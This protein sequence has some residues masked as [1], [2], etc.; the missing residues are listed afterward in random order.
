MD[1]QQASSSG[2]V[3]AEAR[4]GGAARWPASALTPPGVGEDEV[5]ARVLLG[6]AL[7]GERVSG[8]SQEPVGD[9]PQPGPRRPAHRTGPVDGPHL[10]KERAAGD[11]GEHT[12]APDEGE[13]ADGA[14]PA[15]DHDDARVPLWRRAVGPRAA[16]DFEAVFERLNP[17]FVPSD[18]AVVH[19]RRL[20]WLRARRY[21]VPITIAVAPIPPFLPFIGP[22]FQ[23]FSLA[24]TYALVPRSLQLQ[25]GLGPGTAAVVALIPGVVFGWWCVRCFKARRKPGFTLRL[26][27]FTLLI[28]WLEFGPAFSATVHLLSGNTP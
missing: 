1:E 7:E 20:R 10:T 27:T 8:A 16:E 12:A 18:D 21:G 24:R 11:G 23:G 25:D 26:V 5:R 3:E 13:D 14:E 28:G 17:Q 19:R 2:P 22:L 15:A 6:R 9:A 4:Q